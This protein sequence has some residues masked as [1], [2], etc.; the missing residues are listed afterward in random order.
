MSVLNTIA[1]DFL[2]EQYKN[3][4]FVNYDHTVSTSEKPPR[5]IHD[6][7]GVN[8][9]R[10]IPNDSSH[11]GKFTY[12]KMI[13]IDEELNELRKHQEEFERRRK[14]KYVKYFQIHIYFILTFCCS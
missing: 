2:I 8:Y 10:F 5:K 13:L 11:H 1:T 12:Q 14:G 9:S 7:E 4:V 6:N 3:T